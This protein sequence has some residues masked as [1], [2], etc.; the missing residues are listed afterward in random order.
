MVWER[1]EHKETDR[2]TFIF[3]FIVSFY[4][5]IITVDTDHYKVYYFK[6]F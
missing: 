6:Y 3:I 1:I 5:F 4:L 2:Q